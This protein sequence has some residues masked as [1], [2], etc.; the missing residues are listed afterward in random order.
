MLP[1]FF[2]PFGRARDLRK[3]YDLLDLFE[4][5]GED[6]VASIFDG[7]AFRSGGLFARLLGENVP[8]SQPTAEK[9]IDRKT[10]LPTYDKSARELRMG[11]VVMRR[12]G[13][14]NFHEEMI[15]RF[16]EA[17]WKAQILIPAF[18]SDPDRLRETIDQLNTPQKDRPDAYPFQVAWRTRYLGMALIIEK[19][20]MP[21]FLQS[22]S[23]TPAVTSVLMKM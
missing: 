21:I 12:Y 15:E 9:V 18:F 7:T 6:T 14:R 13:K 23:G 4:S 2:R 5:D 16:Q 17:G 3:Y 1:S 20:S 8:H 10:Q 11:D 22:T 19:V